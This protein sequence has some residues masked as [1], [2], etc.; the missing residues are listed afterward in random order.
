MPSL[1]TFDGFNPYANTARQLSVT[2]KVYEFRVAKERVIKLLMI[3]TRSHRIDNGGPSIM[4]SAEV[5]NEAVDTA[6][7]E[8]E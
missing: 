4:V 8:R 7:M 5:R 6:I 2:S 1:I 3:D